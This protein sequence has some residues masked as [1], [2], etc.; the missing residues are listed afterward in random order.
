MSE[1]NVTHLP[2]PKPDRTAAERKRR[3]RANKR[4]HRDIRVTV[5]GHGVTAPVTAPVCRVT[6]LSRPLP[7]VAALA[8]AAVSAVFSI[9]GMTSI[10]VGAFWPVIGMGVALEL[11]K[12]SAVAWLGRAG[13]AVHPARPPKTAVCS[14]IGVL[15]ALNAIWAAPF[16][17]SNLPSARSLSSS[18]GRGHR[19][20]SLSGSFA[21]SGL[22]PGV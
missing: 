16:A 7:L 13:C 5:P 14:L 11:G 8:L 12:L 22:T 3:S 10:F 4:K 1:T 18:V 9:T 17:L 20:A 19:V 21:V 15:M 6:A 2:R